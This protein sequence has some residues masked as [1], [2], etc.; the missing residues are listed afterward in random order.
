[1]LDDPAGAKRGLFALQLHSG[2]PT[3]VRFKDFT[4]E[5]DPKPNLATLISN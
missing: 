3:E 1:D 2:G 5:V 4:L